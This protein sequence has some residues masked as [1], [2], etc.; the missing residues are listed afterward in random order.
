MDIPVLSLILLG[1]VL[2]FIVT[3]FHALNEKEVR[4]LAGKRRNRAI[5]NYF[6][7]SDR[8]ATV[9]V[10][11]KK[12]MNPKG[13]Y[14]YVNEDLSN[15]PSIAA[16]LLKYKKH[17]WA[18]LAFEKNKNVQLI[19]TNKGVSKE[20]VSIHLSAEQILAKCNGFSYSSV[21]I[22]HN[23]P[24]SDPHNQ[25]CSIPSE[26]DIISAHNYS[27]IL[28]NCGINVVEF[29]CER[30]GHYQYH[31]SESDNFLPA[32]DFAKKIHEINGTSKIQNLSLHTE[33][34]FSFLI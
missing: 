30:G 6:T 25:D 10:E 22:F 5:K 20:A 2:L 13:A 7:F 9:D 34:I 1:V 17:E 16:G 27:N 21:L 3:H 28:N 32:T 24:N 23:H 18:I 12:K 31:F 26:Q 8:G 4:T 11:F 33:R 14:Y 15:Y 19:W 29:V